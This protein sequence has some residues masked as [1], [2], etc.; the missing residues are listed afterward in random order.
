MTGDRN[1]DGK[2]TFGVYRPSDQTFY[3]SNDNASVAV[4]R[5]MG[6]AG[7]TPITGDWNGDGTDKI[8]VYHPATSDF[9]GAA[10]DSDTVIYNK[11]F[12]NPGDT[13]ITGAW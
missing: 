1:A 6:V 5:R 13:P 12:G 9:M 11:R 8:G 4:I 3:L 7:D 2:D 10:K